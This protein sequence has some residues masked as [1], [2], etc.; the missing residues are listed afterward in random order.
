MTGLVRLLVPYHQIQA[1]RPA[2]QRAFVFPINA[3]L[4]AG[5]LNADL[6][7]LSSNEQGAARAG[8]V[9]NR[10]FNGVIGYSIGMQKFSVA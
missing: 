6:R 10:A 5:R 1:R 9:D 7:L 8:K 2:S 4:S 3:L